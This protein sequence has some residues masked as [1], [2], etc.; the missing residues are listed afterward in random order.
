MTKTKTDWIACDNL[1]HCETPYLRAFFAAHE[2]PWQMLS[3]IA[4]LCQDLLRQPP[5]GFTLYAPGILIGKNVS[6]DAS[7]TLTAPAIIGD[8]TQIRPG[9]FLRGNVITG[10]GCVLGNSSEVKNA[11]LLDHVQIP[12]YN[13]VGDS[14][15]G[16]HA[17][18]GAGAICSNLKADQAAVVIHDREHGQDYATGLRK[19]GA[20]IADGADVGCNCVLNPGTVL[21]PRTRVYPLTSVR[22]AIPADRIVKDTNCIVKRRDSL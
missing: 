18:L 2:Y 17:H 20:M 21:G 19:C 15:L 22:G 16:N 9:A 1:Y 11:I 8:D 4:S 6:I 7:A 10:Q 3:D 5:E 14:V 12:H 13:Y